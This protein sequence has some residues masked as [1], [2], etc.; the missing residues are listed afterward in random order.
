IP[1]RWYQKD[2]DVFYEPFIVADKFHSMST[3]NTLFT[4]G[5]I[6][7]INKEKMDL[8]KHRM[9]VLDEKIM[10]GTLYGIYKKALKKALQIKSKSVTKA[11]QKVWKFRKLPKEL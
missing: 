9:N 10:Y 1:S 11:L 6:C 7:A 4:G 2:K 3:T 5:Y 8:S